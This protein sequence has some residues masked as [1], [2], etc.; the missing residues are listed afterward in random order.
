MREILNFPPKRQ[1]QFENVKR[2]IDSIAEK[3]NADCSMELAE[4]SQ[5]TGK[6]HNAIDFAEYWGWTDLDSL[7]EI[8]LTPEPPCIRDLTRNEI[9]EIITMIKECLMIGEE[10]KAEYYLE[11]L[12]KSLPLANVI[13]Y[14]MSEEDITKI[15]ENMLLAATNSVITL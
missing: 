5:I 6:Q 11:L 3:V 8:T 12:H 13:D 7:A 2:L 9:E 1:E 14:I 10:N 4:L 15:A